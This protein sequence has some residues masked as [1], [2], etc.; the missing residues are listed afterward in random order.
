MMN[1][2]FDENN[3]YDGVLFAEKK[4]TPNKLQYCNDFVFS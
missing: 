4:L 2:H 1:K 3:E